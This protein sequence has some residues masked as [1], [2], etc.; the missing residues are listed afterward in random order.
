MPFTRKNM[1]YSDYKWNPH[2]GY[3]NPRVT[4]EPDSTL[5]NRQEGYEMLYFINKV[6]ET[7]GWKSASNVD[8]QKIE[9]CVR[10]HVPGGIR[11]QKGI[12]NFL[13]EHREKFW[14]LV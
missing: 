10:L 9:K 13:E 8:Y 14:D 5:L 4:G 11:S 1:F 12:L 3:D 7:W 6:A 2:E